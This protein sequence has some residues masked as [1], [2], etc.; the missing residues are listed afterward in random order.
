MRFVRSSRVE[1]RTLFSSAFQLSSA[2][3]TVCAKSQSG[4]SY[5]MF[6]RAFSMLTGDRAT[7]TKIVSSGS[8]S[9]HARP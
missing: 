6:S 8:V 5:C 1:M 7:F 3:R 9:K 2:R 4:S